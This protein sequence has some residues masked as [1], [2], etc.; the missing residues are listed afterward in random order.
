MP[1]KPPARQREG[2]TVHLWSTHKDRWQRKPLGAVQVQVTMLPGYRECH[3]SV[4]Y[5]NRTK[6][7]LHLADQ[8]FKVYEERPKRRRKKKV[9]H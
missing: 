1:R 9:Q 6:G 4:T 5:N 8:T 7:N 2:T 3:V